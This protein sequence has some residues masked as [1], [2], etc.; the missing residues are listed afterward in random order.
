MIRGSQFGALRYV[1]SGVAIGA[2]DC[3]ASD[4]TP[5]VSAPIPIPA[6]DI[7]EWTYPTFVSAFAFSV[8]I[9]LSISI[10]VLSIRL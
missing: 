2:I 7:C 4:L 1:H 10:I 3:P 9:M 5:L 8:S 6:P